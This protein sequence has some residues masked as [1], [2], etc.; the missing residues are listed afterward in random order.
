MLACLGLLSVP[1]K[2]LRTGAFTPKRHCV[3]A[4][5]EVPGVCFWSLKGVRKV[6]RT[7]CGSPI[8]R[9]LLCAA[10]SS[11]VG[12]VWKTSGALS[13][14]GLHVVPAWSRGHDADHRLHTHVIH[15][16]C[17]VNCYLTPSIGLSS[18]RV[19]TC[20]PRGRG[21]VTCPQMFRW[22]RFAR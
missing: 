10:Q 4:Q 16:C 12:K 2:F 17:C 9:P 3:F 15:Y 21:G 19:A 18:T 20:F 6:S 14:C 13:C 8:S 1:L 22:T 11:C 5:R 7:L